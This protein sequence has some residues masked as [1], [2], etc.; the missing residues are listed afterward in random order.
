M[1]GRVVV[2]A[3]GSPPPAEDRTRPVVTGLSARPA[4]F[5]KR[6]RRCRRPGTVLR[7][8]LS[9]AADVR[10]QAIGRERDGDRVVKTFV[11]GRGRAGTNRVRFHPSRLDEGLYLLRLTATDDAGNTSRTARV[12]FRIVPPPPPPR[13]RSSN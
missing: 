9:E 13:K 11:L 3:E 12:R 6:H 2:Q 1:T 5:C 8:T 4:R 10:A 7:F